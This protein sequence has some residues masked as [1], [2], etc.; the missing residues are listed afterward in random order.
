MKNS[1]D[2]ISNVLASQNIQVNLIETLYFGIDGVFK[3]IFCLVIQ[4]ND[5]LKR[6][7]NGAGNNPKIVYL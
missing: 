6:N 3:V 5:N 2:I 1:K 4:K 7:P